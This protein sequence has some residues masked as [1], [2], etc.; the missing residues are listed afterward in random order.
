MRQR[1]NRTKAEAAKQTAAEQKATEP[2]ITN[3]HHQEA[4]AAT[5]VPMYA[6]KTSNIKVA[7]MLG[8]QFIDAAKYRSFLGIK[9]DKGE[10]VATASAGTL[11][12]VP[13]DSATMDTVPPAAKTTTG[14]EGA[15]CPLDPRH[16]CEVLGEMNNSLEHLERGYRVLVKIREAANKAMEAFQKQFEE[17]LV[18]HVPTEH[19]PILVSIAYNTVSQFRLTIWWMVADECIMPMQHDYLMNHGLASVMQHALE[20]V[21]STYM[22]IVPP[23]PPEPKD[24]LTA[25]LDLLGN[26]SATR[27]PV[28]P[29]VHPT[30]APPVTPIVPPPAITPLPGISAL[31]VRPVPMTSVPVFGGVPLASVPASMA[32]GVSLFQTSLAPPPGFKMLPTSVRV[33]STSSAPA[34]ASTMKASTSG[35]ALPVSIPL[36]GHPG[37]RSDFL[38]DAFKAGSLADLDEEGNAMLDEDLRKMAGD[39]SRKQVAGSKHIHDKDINEDEEAED[40]DGSMFEDLDEPLPAP[41]KRS[42]KAKSPT[43]SGPVNWPPAE[44]DIVRQNRYA[45]DQSEMRDYHRNYLTAVDQKTFNLKNHSKYLD[46]ILAKPGITQDVVFTVEKGQAYFAE[47][48]KVLTDLYDQGVLTP[49]PASP[50]SKQFPDR[51]VVD[52]IYVMVIVAH[53]SSQNIADNDPDGFG[54]TCLMGLWGLHTE[55]A[56]QQCRKTC[57]DGVNRITAGFCPFC[58]FWM[59]NDSALNNHVRKHYSMV[60]SCYHDGYTTWSMSAMKHHMRTDHGIMMES[61]PEKCKRTK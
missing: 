25:F 36:P 35:V 49:L 60:M 38:T 48:C 58:E 51:E 43:K 32:T 18:P 12:Q 42:S 22:R 34:A 3:E 13:K 8:V 11:A 17:A 61:A 44:V 1:L 50:G 19:L 45:M 16:L 9:P 56:L 5:R 57:S 39:V 31:G 59:M 24:N 52:I 28:T 15:K 23:R 21:P 7:P 14:V 53:P 20:K 46:I 41:V 29:I 33:T 30:V 40:G 6:S 27:A 26:T 54:R 2:M 4:L 55:K 37:G 10:E 47:T